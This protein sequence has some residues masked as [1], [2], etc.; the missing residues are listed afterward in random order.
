MT[1]RVGVV[2]A[3]IS[4]LTLV[5]E[6]RK[7]GHEAVCFEALGEPGGVVR[8]RGVGGRVL[9]LGPQRLRLTPTV[10]SLLDELDLRDELR[11]GDDDKPLY[12]YHDGE[13][14]VV[15]LS[16]REALTT[17][18]LSWR[19][20]ARV[21][22]EPFTRG[23]EEGETVGG[24]LTR[25]FG[26]E[27]AR[28]CFGPVYSGLYGTDPDE[29]LYEY[30]L[31]RALERAGVGRSVLV[32]AALKTLKG[33]ETP[34]V[35]AFD[36]GL[37]RLPHELRERHSEAVR[38]NTPVREVVEA[39]GGTC[40]GVVT[41]DDRVEVDEV[42]LTTPAPTTAEIVEGIDP[43]S[44]EALGRLRYNPIAVVHVDSGFCGE[45]LGALVPHGGEGEGVR[46]SGA[47][48]N[49]SFLDRDRLFTCYVDPGSFPG[50]EDAT[51]ETLGK[52][53]SE[54][55]E[56]LTGASAEPV[57]VHRWDPGMPAYDATWTAT[58]DI[59]LP[60]GVHL[61][62]NFVERP[63]IPG[64][65]RHARR[66]ADELAGDL[67]LPPSVPYAGGTQYLHVL[68]RGERTPQEDSRPYRRTQP[69][70]RHAA[71]RGRP[72]LHSRARDRR[73]KVSRTRCVRRHH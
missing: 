45:G 15:P 57:N 12:V 56:R 69:R 13:L 7:E 25:K 33:R 64:R 60:R 47:T 58:D 34:P 23:A 73:G 38:L 68:R 63:G 50:M 70:K 32:W 1:Q 52:V 66:L 14:S 17:D 40:Y 51:D 5:H 71:T 26:A 10:A 31:G 54:D 6:L 53:A 46:I 67:V 65:I 20:K 22:A 48:W 9:E 55:F 72:R 18:L 61:C 3:G 29:M 35:C 24:Y 49:A 43:V 11:F 8:S 36:E 16:V 27:A 19:G 4:G 2:G 62:S 21:L 42:V 39:E 41:D 30:S 44:S 59:D 28:R 37:G